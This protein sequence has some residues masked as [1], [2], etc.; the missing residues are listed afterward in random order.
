MKILIAFDNNNVNRLGTDYKRRTQY[1]SIDRLIKE[2]E[3]MKKAS[4]GICKVYA[5]N[6]SDYNQKVCEMDNIEFTN[7]IQK[8]GIRLI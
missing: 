6:E 4:F 7:H 5:I 2:A 1:R 8:I 3:T